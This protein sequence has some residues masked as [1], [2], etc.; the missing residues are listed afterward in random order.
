MRLLDGINDTEDELYTFDSIMET[1]VKD[2]GLDALERIGKQKTKDTSFG[3]DIE[4]NF[5]EDYKTIE[6]ELKDK[7]K[8]EE[9]VNMDL[10]LFMKAVNIK[11]LIEDY[12]KFKKV[13]E[14]IK[15]DFFTFIEFKE[16]KRET[17]TYYLINFNRGDY[18]VYLPKE[19]WE[20]LKEIM[21]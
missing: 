9:L 5:N 20:L 13:L 17:K 16:E 15:E 6:K 18:K 14:I 11:G 12:Q 19:K 4:T 21:L 8:F 2:T 3:I 10:D 7:E 1:K